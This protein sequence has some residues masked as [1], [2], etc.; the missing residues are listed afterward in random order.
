M[1]D[2]ACGLYLPKLISDWCPLSQVIV[3]SLTSIAFQAAQFGTI[4]LITMGHALDA[5]VRYE[6]VVDVSVQ[7]F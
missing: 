2:W 6:L 5:V 4:S 3:E 7:R 1:A